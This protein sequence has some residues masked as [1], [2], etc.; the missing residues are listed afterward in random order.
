MNWSLNVDLSDELILCTTDINVSITVNL[1]QFKMFLYLVFS[2]RFYSWHT[3]CTVWWEF[4]FLT[5]PLHC[6][7][8]VF[9]LGTPSALCGESFYS[10]HTQGTVWWEFLFL[11]HPLHCVVRVFILG[12][13]SALCGESFYSWH[14]L[15]TVW[16]E[17]LFLACSVHCLVRAFFYWAHSLPCLKSIFWH[18]HHSANET[19]YTYLVRF[20]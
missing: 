11:A 14:T 6:V 20:Q 1:W 12:T 13:P 17:F 7:V 15:C 10:W 5:H 9:I 4:L 19:L 18:T 2:L 8:R 3:Q 16:W